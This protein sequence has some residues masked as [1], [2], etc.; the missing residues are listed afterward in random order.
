MIFVAK[1]SSVADPGSGAFSAPGSGIRDGKKSRSRVNI[2][3][4]F[5]EPSISFLVKKY[6]IKFFDPDPGSCQS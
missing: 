1:R 3:D 2:E 6:R 5:L 4:L